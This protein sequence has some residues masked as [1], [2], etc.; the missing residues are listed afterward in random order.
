RRALW[1]KA[2]RRLLSEVNTVNT[3]QVLEDVVLLKEKLTTWIEMVKQMPGYIRGLEVEAANGALV[4]TH[5]VEAWAADLANRSRP[6]AEIEADAQQCLKAYK[7]LVND[8]EAAM[9]VVCLFSWRHRIDPTALVKLWVEQNLA[10]Y[11]EAMA[12]LYRV[13][14]FAEGAPPKSGRRK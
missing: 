4:A 14:L 6:L 9:R 3:K 5:A 8:I 7:T 11:T 10:A 12:V 2:N 13:E 1:P